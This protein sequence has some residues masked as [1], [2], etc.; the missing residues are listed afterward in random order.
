MVLWK[1]TRRNYTNIPSHV[2]CSVRVSIVPIVQAGKIEQKV[3]GV[4]SEVHFWALPAYP[5][6]RL[7]WSFIADSESVAELGIE[8]RPLFQLPDPQEYFQALNTI[9]FILFLAK[10]LRNKIMLPPEIIFK[11]LLVCSWTT[12]FQ[13]LCTVQHYLGTNGLKNQF[14]EELCM[15]CAFVQ[16]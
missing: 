1:H 13:G 12:F 15:D 14:W 9:N 8:S 7:S 4:S 6:S 16:P 10:D 3:G 5:V 2:L 11:I